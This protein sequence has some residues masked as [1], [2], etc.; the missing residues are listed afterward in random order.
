MG[1]SRGGQERPCADHRSITVKNS[2]L[3]GGL[4]IAS[5][6]AA[7]G[8]CLP[9]L[10]QTEPPKRPTRT[11]P[12]APKP[13]TPPPPPQPKSKTPGNQPGAK[14]NAKKDAP[15]PGP[16][17]KQEQQRDLTLAVMVR[18][19]LN[20][21]NSKTTYRDPFTGRTVDMPKP[22]PMTFKTLG[23]VFPVVPSTGSSDLFINEITGTLRVNGREVTSTPEILEGY[24][25]PVKLTRWD[26]GTTDA[27][28]EAKVVQLDMSIGMRCYNTVFDEQA[29]Y[30]VKWPSVYP[31]EVA[32]N[33]QPQ[34][35]VE[36]GLDAA[37]NIR[38]YDDQ[39]LSVALAGFLEQEGIKD[40]KTQ[41]PAYVAKVIAGK[42]WTLIQISGD[43][44]NMTRTGEL[45]G[46]DIKPPADTLRDKRGTEQDVT[47]LMAALYRKAGLPTRTVIGFDVTSKDAKFLQKS[48]K[49]NRLRS[50][51]EFA[52]YD[53]PNNTIN[54]VP[55]DLARMRKTTNRPP[56]LDRAWNYFGT[57]DELSAVTPFALHF[58]PPTDVVAYGSPGFWGWF[59]TPAPAKNAAQALRFTATT[60]SVRGGQP[61]RDPK[62][63]ETNKPN[64]PATPGTPPKKGY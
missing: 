54:W 33:L 42:V 39:E 18:V 29:A 34:L 32:K 15:T 52:L 6:I 13:V 35:Y 43:G 45:S 53:E 50:W 28:T 11:A 36:Q 8:L 44:L 48:N 57:H 5:L 59:V 64:T 17:V 58:H 3:R 21:P 40:A 49:N 24:P 1:E 7:M 51:V 55:V 20:S 27:D 23:F 37:G 25:G 61:A 2:S 60:S 26:A 19:D 47:A 62:N 63:P 9:A 10:A 16:Y 22:T 31:A 14:T 4:S 41:P 46:M 12:T 38:P 30:Q 56:A